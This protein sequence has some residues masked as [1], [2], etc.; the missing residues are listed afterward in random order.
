MSAAESLAMAESG[1]L[2]F[3]FQNLSVAELLEDVLSSFS[4][5]GWAIAHQLASAH[6]GS[7]SVESQIGEG[8]T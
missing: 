8:T 2:D 7:I 5:P 3:K 6:G 1:T 4:G